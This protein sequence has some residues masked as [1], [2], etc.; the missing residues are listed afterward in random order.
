MGIAISFELLGIR[1]AGLSG[2]ERQGYIRNRDDL[3]DRSI[4]EYEQTREGVIVQKSEF[5]V[6]YHEWSDA[7]SGMRT[8]KAA[9]LWGP[10][11]GKGWGESDR[12]VAP[13]IDPIVTW[14]LPK[15]E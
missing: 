1:Q 10:D 7:E 8:V 9:V 15:S 12:A 13:A 6:A 14:F 11:Q 5:S 4:F 3:S 2:R